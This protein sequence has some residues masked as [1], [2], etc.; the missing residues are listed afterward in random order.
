MKW[1]V[2]GLCWRKQSQ[3]ACLVW[4]NSIK[5]HIRLWNKPSWSNMVPN[6]EGA[7]HIKDLHRTL[8]FVPYFYES[9]TLTHLNRISV[10]WMFLPRLMQREAQQ[11]SVTLA[12]LQHST[13]KARSKHGHCNFKLDASY[14]ISHCF[15]STVGNLVSFSKCLLSKYHFLYSKLYMEDKKEIYG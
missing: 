9:V 6:L 13:M 7:F 12:R 1:C 10:S 3:P 11:H 4:N 5:F 8:Q 14:I 2:G 15:L